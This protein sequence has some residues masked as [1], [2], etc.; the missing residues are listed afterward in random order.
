MGLKDRVTQRIE[1]LRKRRP[2]VDHLF[3]TAEHY[4]AVKGSLQAGA[5]TYFAFLS[6]FPILAL[7]FAVSGALVAVAPATAG[8]QGPPAPPPGCNVVIT[9][10]AFVAPSSSSK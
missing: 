2:V 10:P 3:R 9:T 5:V 7:A 1:R 4:S 8:A 6:F